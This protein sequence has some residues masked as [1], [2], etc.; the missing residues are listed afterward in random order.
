MK[1]HNRMHSKLAGIVA[2]MLVALVSVGTVSA[3]VI[4]DCTYDGYVAMGGTVFQNSNNYLLPG[5]PDSA[6]EGPMQTFGYA[7][8]KFNTADLPTEAVSQ[9]YLQLDVIAL[10]DGMTWPAT[11]TGNLGVFAVTADVAGID[12]DNAG[13]FRDS[14][15]DTATDSVSM[16]GEGLIYLD[17]T[18]IVNG[19]IDGDNDGLVLASPGGL[20][21]RLHSSETTDG[22]APVITSVPEPATM[23][24]L[25]CGA[26]GLISRRKRN[27]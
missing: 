19:W 15:A 8:C 26:L 7:F 14:I 12:A 20:M 25:A 3:D 16:T 11:G 2:A 22:L 4:A 6:P 17:V 24:L 9:A 5:N 13:T 27:G 18:D 21:P 1:I 10:Q 23:G